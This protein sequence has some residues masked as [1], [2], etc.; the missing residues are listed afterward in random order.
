MIR[1]LS[2]KDFAI[3]EELEVSFNEGLTVITG[4]T[5]AGKSLILKSLSVLLG[6]KGEKTFVRSGAERSVLELEIESDSKNFFRRLLSKSGRTRSFHNEEPCSESDYKKRSQSI[7]DFHGQNEQQLIMNPDNHIDYLDSFLKENKNLAKIGIL[8]ED[9]KNID[10]EIRSTQKKIENASTR[11]ELLDFQINEIESIDPK[12]DE[13]LSLSKEFKRLKNIEDTI[14]TLKNIN[15]TLNESDHSIYKQLSSAIS[16]LERLSR[17][18]EDLTPFV[19]EIQNATQSI[20]ESSVGLLQYVQNL[21]GED[22]N[23]GQIEERLHGIEMLKRKYG[24]TIGYVLQYLEEAYV[25]LKEMQGLDKKY[26]DLL[27]RKNS[28]VKE[29][30][31]LSEELHSKRK[32]I[33]K[34]IS[35]QIIQEMSNLNMPNAIF[36]IR[37]F[38][39]SKKNSPVI[40]ENENVEI[41][42]KGFDIVEFYLSANPGESPK[43][44]VKIASG[45][46]TSRIM[47]AIKTVLKDFDPVS[48]LIFDEIDS[49]ISGDAAEKVGQ[50]LLKLSKDKQVFCITHLPQIAS[51]A[52]NH[53]YVY[54]KVSKSKTR[55][56]AKYLNEKDKINAIAELYGNN[57]KA[58]ASISTTKGSS[59]ETYG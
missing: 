16:N 20:Q 1:R 59:S 43:P 18:D 6:A 47:L 25:E 30:Q 26:A 36:D 22:N 37:I 4:E 38:Q 7:A 15:L 34:K 24:G 48:T 35:T 8:Y 51:K 12:K 33:A 27:E 10:L 23:L 45:G 32:N 52:K 57:S 31:N 56:S 42:P 53:L 14:S 21:D 29:F 46:E 28:L 54:K 17:F 9:L 50:A 2:V 3:L 58:Y 19:N 41:N 44:L 13:D 40:F 5:G 55:V 39:K 49:G 11:K